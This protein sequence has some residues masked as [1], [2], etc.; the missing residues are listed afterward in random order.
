MAKKL[1]GLI[2]ILLSC[3]TLFAQHE[4]EHFRNNQFSSGRVSDAYKKYNDT[5]AAEFRRKGMAYPPKDIYIRAFKSQNVMELWARNN[6]NNE[7]KLIKT[8]SICAISGK[9]GPKRSQG[10]RQVPEGYYF[11]EEF[12]PKS[13]YY[14]SM[15]L[16]YPNYTDRMN[17]TPAHLGGDIYVHGGC[18]T[19]GCLPMSDEGI[20]EL[21]T[22]CLSAKMNGQ[23]FIPVHIFPTRLNRSGMN[24]LKNEFPGDYTRQQFWADLKAGYEYFEK[25]HKLLPVM[26]S[27]DGRYAN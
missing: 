19:I 27:P 9:L 4:E 23:E 13:E 24:Y 5:L 12:N 11:I 15:L 20:K 26:Y 2:V 10:D 14:L 17:G 16:N 6:E 1:L 18:V 7:Y 8:Y 25:Y 22:V 3:H 21:Y